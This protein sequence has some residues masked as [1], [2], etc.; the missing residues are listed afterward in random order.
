MFLSQLT[1]TGFLVYFKFSSGFGYY[2]YMGITS[3]SELIFANMD[4]F[5]TFA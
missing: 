2:F 1:R 3:F 4:W 5:M